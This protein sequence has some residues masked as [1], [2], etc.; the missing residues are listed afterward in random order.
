MA[1]PNSALSKVVAHRCRRFSSALRSVISFHCRGT[2]QHRTRFASLVGCHVNLAGILPSL[3]TCTDSKIWWPFR[4]SAGHAQGRWRAP[5]VHRIRSGCSQQFI[6]R[7][8]MHVCIGHIDMG[9]RFVW[10]SAI[11]IPSA[12]ILEN[13]GVFAQFPLRFPSPPEKHEQ[14]EQTD[15]PD[16]S[17]GSFRS[18]AL[19]CWRAHSAAASRWLYQ[20]RHVYRRSCNPDGQALETALFDRKWH[21][22][23]ERFR[24]PSAGWSATSL[25][26]CSKDSSACFFP[27][28]WGIGGIERFEAGDATADAISC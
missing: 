13:G 14:A 19:S 21:Q 27:G 7:L 26:P 22:T 2:K 4:G 24:H 23:Q 17:M 12:G 8:A 9:I 18:L 10:A 5:R 16:G 25:L 6:D 3:R 20:C 15:Q 28:V 1:R 11:T